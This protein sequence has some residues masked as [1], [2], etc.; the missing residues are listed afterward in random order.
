MGKDTVVSNQVARTINHGGSLTAKQVQER[1]ERCKSAN[2]CYVSLKPLNDE[3]VFT[4]TTKDGQFSML[5]KYGEPA[6]EIMSK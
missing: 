4:L 6:L 2:L 5:K 3:N 1:N